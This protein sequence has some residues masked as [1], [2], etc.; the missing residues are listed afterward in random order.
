MLCAKTRVFAGLPK[1]FT[2]HRHVIPEN[3]TGIE[4]PL[5]VNGSNFIIHQ[6]TNP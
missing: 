5:A 3:Q 2:V 6:F 4:L 1:M